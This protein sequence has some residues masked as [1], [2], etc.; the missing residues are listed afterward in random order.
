MPVPRGAP[1]RHLVLRTANVLQA[2]IHGRI[3]IGW[4]NTPDTDKRF[5]PDLGRFLSS[6]VLVEHPGPRNPAENHNW[7]ER[8]ARLR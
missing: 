2:I 3:A 1:W 7:R 6:S 8:W 5:V 4:L